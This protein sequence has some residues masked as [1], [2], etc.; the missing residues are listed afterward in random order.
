LTVGDEENCGPTNK[1][2][3]EDIREGKKKVTTAKLVKNGGD[4]DTF[5]GGFKNQ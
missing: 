5:K 1:V 4:Q 3:R 2:D